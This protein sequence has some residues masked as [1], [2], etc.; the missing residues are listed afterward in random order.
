M[1]DTSD[2]PPVTS[3]PRVPPARRWLPLDGWALIG[4]IIAGLVILPIATVFWLAL[5]P[6]ENIWP[7]MIATTLPR[8]LKNSIL[9]MT[10]VGV[11]AGCIGTLTAWM[12][13]MYRFPG[14]NVLQWAL[15]LPLS[16]PA[17]IAAFAVVD[18]LEYAGPLQTWLRDVFGWATP[19]DYM[20]PEIR[21]RGIAILVLA[22]ALYPYVYFLTRSVFRTQSGAAIEVARALGC[23]PIGSFLRVGLPLA[24]PA[25]AASV[26]IVMMETLNEFGAMEFFAVQTLTTGIFSVWLDGNN[27]GGAAQLACVILVFVMV[28]VVLEKSSR[29]RLKFHETARNM[30]PPQPL[31]LSKVAGLITFVFCI[32]PILTGFVLPMAILLDHAF[33]HLELWADADLWRATLR[34][35]TLAG[36]AAILTVAAGVL[37][38]FSVR[39][40]RNGFMK[41]LLPVATI[42]YA[43]PGA[44][45]GLGI[46]YPFAALDHT[47][48]DIILWVT[49]FDPGL[50]LVGSM[51]AV[52]LAYCVRFFAI[53]VGT[54]DAAF[55]KISPSLGMASRSLGKTPRQTLAKLYTPLIKGSIATAGLLIFVDA[56]KELPATLLLY[57]QNTLAT[58]VYAKASLED[59]EGAASAALVIVLISLVAVAIV[60]IANRD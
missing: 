52:I 30:R 21:S 44:V 39:L 25:I 54:I 29:R 11:L 18:F 27:A 42:G 37:L 9:M 58:T 50:L 36:I 8:Y 57:S 41:R 3:G 56:A 2:I 20:F 1:A 31:V 35:I 43:A 32:V 7:H 40:M 46:L 60:S 24:R 45:L 16:L 34:T 59:I 15:L 48:A 19:R 47:L 4:L 38:V 55:T 23:G 53:S 17:Y 6:A 33:G 22:S 5:F 14:R 26:A 13:V 28:L 12:V 49:G 51:G 10:G